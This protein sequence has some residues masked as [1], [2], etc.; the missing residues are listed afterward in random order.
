M[1]LQEIDKIHQSAIH[2]IDDAVINDA[3]DLISQLVAELGRA[4]LNDELVRLRMS[5]TFMLKY[6]EQGVKD[7][8]RDEILAN[9][10][11]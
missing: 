3:F 11:Q 4:D 8:Q 2:C 10:R 1:T 7:P 6:L 9:I 5:Y